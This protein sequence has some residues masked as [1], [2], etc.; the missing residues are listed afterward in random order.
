MSRTAVHLRLLA[1]FAA[2]A[3]AVCLV[4][5]SHTSPAGAAT[6]ITIAPV[7]DAT[8]SSEYPS[9]TYGSVNRLRADGSPLVR[10]YLRFDLSG[11]GTIAKATL[12][13]YSTSSSSTGYRVGA[14]ADNSWSES[15]ISA[16]NA[17]AVG[18]LGATS[19][20]FAA[21][22][23]VSVDV[24]GLVTRSSANLAV[25]AMTST[26]LSFDSREA[27]SAYAPRLVVQARD[28]TAPT[29]PGA[30]TASVTPAPA[31]ALSWTAASDDVGVTGY[32]V[33]RDGTTIV[34]TGGKTLAYS[35]SAV[36]AGHTYAYTVAAVDAAG[37]SSPQSK[38]LSVTIPTPTPTPTPPAPAS[39]PTTPSTDTIH[40]IFREDENAI[41]QPEPAHE[42]ALRGLLQGRER[43]PVHRRPR[44]RPDVGHGRR[45]HRLPRRTPSRST[46]ST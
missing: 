18:T 9:S 32:V 40:T 2:V 10:S 3:F 14:V 21:N 4:A 19:N 1:P 26:A 35:D 17:P 42:D 8:I 11:V 44:R 28:T 23:W 41:G 27:G 39:V 7:A 25:L 24:T 29:T 13:L 31:T 5:L 6:S 36:T 43:R 12:S 38:P 15:T 16:A 30:L 45:L 22:A 20:A 37:N 46:S 33:R 34:T